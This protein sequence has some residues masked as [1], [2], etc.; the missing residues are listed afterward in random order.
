MLGLQKDFLFE[1]LRVISFL[2][3]SEEEKEIVRNCRNHE[4]I[5][6]WMYSDSIISPEEHSNFI[7]SLRSNDRNYY[8]LVQKGHE[9]IGVISLNKIDSKNKN[10]YLGIYSNP[11]CKIKD[12]GSL[13]IECLKKLAFDT[14]KLHTLKLEVM[15]KNE[16]AIN[17]YKKSG[18]EEEGRL[19][20]FILKDNNWHDMIIMGIIEGENVHGT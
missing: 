1:D 4:T 12:K 11:Y 5:R 16:K 15:C 2:N 10:A 13:L 19:R 9:Y 8:W 18:F 6:K 20:G 3:M 14:V 7:K 17:F